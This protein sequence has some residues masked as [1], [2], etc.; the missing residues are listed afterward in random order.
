MFFLPAVSTGI[1]IWYE[2]FACPLHF[3]LCKCEISL[4]QVFNS[5]RDTHAP[6]LSVLYPKTPAKEHVEIAATSTVASKNEM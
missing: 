5:Y 4:A 2:A 1:A 3:F 6:L